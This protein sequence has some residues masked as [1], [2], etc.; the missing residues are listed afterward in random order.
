MPP[1]NV[2]FRNLEA[3]GLIFS[4]ISEKGAGTPA[5]YRWRSSVALPS[6]VRFNNPILKNQKCTKMHPR[7]T[8]FF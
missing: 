8:T 6:P 4:L 5:V 1:R 7:E 3:R 2:F